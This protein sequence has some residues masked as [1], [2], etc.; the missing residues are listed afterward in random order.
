MFRLIEN[1][2]KRRA[3]LNQTHSQNVTFSLSLLRSFVF[4]D[5]VYILTVLIFLLFLSGDVHLNPGPH[6][7][8]SSVSFCTND[9]YNF[10][11]LPNH[12]SLFIIMFRVSQI[13]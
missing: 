7:D 11:S 8:T 2:N 1:R 13:R 5:I 4:L 9:L 3:P 10:L 12:L 6:S